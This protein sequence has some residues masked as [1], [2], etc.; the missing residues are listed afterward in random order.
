MSHYRHLILISLLLGVAPASLASDGAPDGLPAQLTEAPSGDG[1]GHREIINAQALLTNPD[2][3][4][5]GLEQ[6]AWAFIEKG[7]VDDSATHYQQALLCADALET[8]HPSRRQ[9]SLLIRGHVYHQ[10][11]QFEK[12]LKLASELVSTRGNSMDHALHG[13]ILF[14]IGK[15]EDAAKAYEKTLQL[16]PG[17]ASYVRAAEMR[18]ITGDPKGAIEAALLAVRAGAARQPAPLAWAYSRLSY[19]LHAQGRQVESL[20][21]AERALDLIPNYLPANIGKARA[22]LS[23]EKAPAAVAVLEPYMSK[24]Q[25]PMTWWLARECHQ[26]AGNASQTTRWQKAIMTRGVRKDPRTVSLFLSTINRSS[27]AA[28]QLAEAEIRVRQDIH[29]HD[30]LAFALWRHWQQA[31]VKDDA[32]LTRASQAIDAALT[33][34]TQDARLWLHAGLIHQSLG[35]CEKSSRYFKR[36]KAS[37]HM[38]Y[39]SERQL[40]ADALENFR[41]SSK[42]HSDR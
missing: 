4:A 30:T 5:D 41:P 33:H 34:D 24:D 3:A 37:A 32:L 22:L 11:H 17:L 42:P 12:A 15:I 38:L 40:L 25:E 39:P 8:R 31:A 9:D 29:T 2:T 21:A 10:H 18:W 26:A 14:D 16:R 6:L 1:F 19:Y 20:A 35:A 7:M 36:A 13:D 23:Q 28:L 27:E